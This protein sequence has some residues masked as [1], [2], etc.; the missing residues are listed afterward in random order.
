MAVLLGAIGATKT[1][2]KAKSKAK[3]PPIVFHYDLYKYGD[4]GLKFVKQVKIRRMK[5]YAA[6]QAM[7]DYIIKLKK[8][9]PGFYKFEL[10]KTTG[11]EGRS[12]Y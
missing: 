2:A 11:E 4:D 1:K 10:N 7:E 9:K 12:I 8:T 6:R 5:I 3:L